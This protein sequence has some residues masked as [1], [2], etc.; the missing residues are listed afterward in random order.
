M[1][2]DIPKAIRKISTIDKLLVF[3][4]KSLSPY[5]KTKKIDFLNR[6]LKSAYLF[7]LCDYIFA[8]AF[9][10]KTTDIP[11]HSVIL[12]QNYGNEYKH[13]IKFLEENNIIKRKANYKIGEYSKI[14]TIRTRD[15]YRGYIYDKVLIKKKIKAKLDMFLSNIN[16]TTINKE[17][18]EKL[19][20]NLFNVSVDKTTLQYNLDNLSGTKWS[21]ELTIKGI[22]N[23]E[24]KTPWFSFDKYGRFHSSLTTL[25]SEI[26]NNN[27]LIGGKKTKEIDIKNS[28]PMFLCC[29]IMENLDSIDIDYY[30]FRF[31]VELV[32]NNNFYKHIGDVFGI[33]KKK[34]V[35]EEFYKII[36]GYN[37]ISENFNKF[38]NEFPT[39]TRF[40]IMYKKQAGDY[41]IL[42]QKLQTIES[43]FIYNKVLKEVLM[44][45][46]DLIFFTVHDSIVVGYDNYSLVISIFQKH[47]SDILNNINQVCG[48]FQEVI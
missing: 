24:Q 48:N 37:T 44:V 17:V 32:T 46:N 43:N 9:I 27:I 38:S 35:K 45:K 31:F 26:R 20:I 15:V 2:D 16:D 28:Q 11:I 12:K 19:I 40:I 30:E 5:F 33:G 6:K 39:I 41:R 36:F 14:Y 47:I 25:K 4:P 18:R 21:K 7:D 8:R 1:I 23:I 3:Y 42:S 10:E 22:E 13:Y 34:K 29:L